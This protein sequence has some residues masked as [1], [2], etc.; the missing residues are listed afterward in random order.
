MAARIQCSSEDIQLQPPEAAV[1]VSASTMLTETLAGSISTQ[2]FPPEFQATACE[3]THPCNVHC[4]QTSAEAV[5][6]AVGV[7]AIS[8]YNVA[9][10]NTPIF[11]CFEKQIVR[12]VICY[13]A[14]LCTTL[15]IILQ[16]STQQLYL[17]VVSLASVQRQQILTDSNAGICLAIS[18]TA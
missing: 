11:L 13:E 4:H 5:F 15:T 7:N 9:L 2:L 3:G 8:P 10:C 14:R 18:H 6:E 12:N 17:L 16:D 1:E